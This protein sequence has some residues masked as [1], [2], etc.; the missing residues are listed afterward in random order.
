MVFTDLPLTQEFKTLG[1]DDYLWVQALFN[2]KELEHLRGV[3]PS[4]P[5]QWFLWRIIRMGVINPDV[6]EKAMDVST[7]LMRHSSTI[8]MRLW[9]MWGRLRTEWV[10]FWML[11]HLSC[12]L[13][14]SLGRSPRD[15]DEGPV[16][17]PRRDGLS[18]RV[19]RWGA[20]TALFPVSGGWGS[21]RSSLLTGPG[22]DCFSEGEVWSS[23]KG[24]WGGK[25]QANMT[26]LF[27]FSS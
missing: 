5:H 16:E 17:H 25:C 10:Q 4:N 15:N 8:G 12:L 9:K 2:H 13:T 6:G 20:L 27:C 11:I 18:T 7:Q 3:E 26:S 21:A 14:L 23:G 19:Q 24:P 1:M 22:V